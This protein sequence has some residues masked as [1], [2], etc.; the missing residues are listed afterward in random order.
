MREN[1][2][3]AEEDRKGSGG[4]LGNREAVARERLR[5]TSSQRDNM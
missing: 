3:G 4:D 5:E 1:L 2:E